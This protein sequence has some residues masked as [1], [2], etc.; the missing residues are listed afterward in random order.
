M[1]D[2]LRCENVLNLDNIE[3]FDDSCNYAKHVGYYV[4]QV[5]VLKTAVAATCCD[6]VDVDGDVD[7]AA[8][9][10]VVD[11]SLFCDCALCVDPFLS[12]M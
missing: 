2:F 1:P 4:R 12:N 11:L 6:D 5:Y 3:I 8:Y 9:V 7:V 10:I